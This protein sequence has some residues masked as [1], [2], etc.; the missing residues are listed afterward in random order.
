M[1]KLLQRFKGRRT[2]LIAAVSTII[3]I[4]EL[5]E[6]RSIIPADYWPYFAIGLALLMLVMRQIT[7]SPVGDRG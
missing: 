1:K 4:L 5:S 3:P 2:Q 7:T 6:W